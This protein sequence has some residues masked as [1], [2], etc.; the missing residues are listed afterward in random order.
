V[1]GTFARENKV[2]I[3]P[4]ELD[5]VATPQS[6]RLAPEAERFLTRRF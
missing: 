1:W 6:R 4:L 2:D 3:H 5:V